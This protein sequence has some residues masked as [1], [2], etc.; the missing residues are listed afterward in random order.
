MSK[1]LPT[2]PPPIPAERVSP[3]IDAEDLFPD[4]PDDAPTIATSVPFDLSPKLVRKSALDQLTRAYRDA[5]ELGELGFTLLVGEPGMGKSY[6]VKR[7]CDTAIR[8]KPRPRV[9]KAEADGGEEAYAVFAK[10]LALRF[11]IAASD[12]NQDAQEKIIEGVADILDA[13]RVTEVAHILANLCRVPFENSPVIGPLLDAPQ[14]L[15]TRTFIAV[16]RLLAADAASSP[17]VLAIENLELC[18]PETIN[19][20]HYLAAGM[21]SSRVFILGTARNSLFARHPSFGEG[22]VPLQRIELGPLT[23]DESVE[24]LEAIG[25]QLDQVPEV[26]VSHARK[27]GGSPRAIFELFRLM[28]ES[29]V[30]VRSGSLSW[31]LDDELFETLNLPESH[32]DLVAER[33]RVMP[34]V[35]ADILQK[36][37]VVGETFWLDAVV[38][39]VRIGAHRSDDPDGPTLA[40]IAAAGDHTRILVAQTLGKLVEREW[41]LPVTETSLPGEREYRFN[42]PY[43]WSSV[44]DGTE[45]EARERAHKLVAQ[46]LQLRPEGEDEDSQEAIGRHLELAGDSA[47]AARC[48]RTAAEVARRGFSNEKA[49]RLYAMAL[50]CLGDT[51]FTARIYLWHD[52]GSVFELKGDLESALGAYERMLRLSWTTA[53]RAK[54]GVAFNKMG[55][56]WRRKGDLKLALEYLERGGE[57]FEQAGDARGIAGSLD[58][59]GQVLYLLGR[60]DEAFA[61]VTQGLQKR[62]KGGDQRSIAHSLSNLGNIQKDRGKFDAAE[63]CHRDALSIRR[64]IGDRAGVVTS[65]NNLAVLAFERGDAKAAKAGWQE[66]LDEAE[67]MGSLPLQA[68]ALTNLGELA[69]S[70]NQNDEARRR[71]GEAIEIATELSDPLLTSEATRNLAL[72]EH[73]HGSAE[74]A[75]ELAKRANDIATGAGLRDNQGRALLTL[76]EV[77]AGTLFDAGDAEDSPTHPEMQAAERYFAKGIKVLREIGNK[78]ELGKGLERY[79]RYKIE[80]HEVSSG[81]ALLEEALGIFKGLGMQEQRRQVE[82]VL[83]NL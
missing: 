23:A 32:E 26:L 63:H 37:A 58:D 20:L 71:L 53:S 45:A 5:V 47:G 73:Y 27:L 70:Q 19:L 39:Q 79:G 17:L 72:V 49:I 50:N 68:L 42:Y 24:L 81:A 2:V 57:L 3:P 25:H 35:E 36:S 29:E 16:R 6:T 83:A 46:W 76:G 60:Y 80:H 38:A 15:E 82:S 4:P 30:I 18:G 41:I 56:V 31:K 55:R 66:G 11:G 7:L 28:L 21:A 62:G 13:A 59:V 67:D 69:R 52:L 8:S 65:L 40:E 43:L 9:L 34:G 48:Y 54:A 77:Y 61:K 78:A 14:Q 44:Y 12:S 33:V 22:D 75:R 64:D 10:L 51:D 1:R 74:K